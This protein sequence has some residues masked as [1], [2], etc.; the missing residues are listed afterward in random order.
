M[1]SPDIFE[2][3]QEPMTDHKMDAQ[4]MVET[5][6]PAATNQTAR[7][8]VETANRLLQERQI[9][10]ER[11]GQFIE[12]QK[13]KLQNYQLRLQTAEN[14]IVAL[15]TENQK[16]QQKLQQNKTIAQQLIETHIR[17]IKGA[18]KITQQPE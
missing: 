14:E 9:N 1:T 15:K 13:A 16:L 7:E 12:H 3:Q 8:I 10:D 11:L 6:L 5:N 4:E 17:M 2:T 18:K